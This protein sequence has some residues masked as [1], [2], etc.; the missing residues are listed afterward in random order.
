[1]A[2]IEFSV[3]RSKYKIE[4]PENE[5]A[6]LMRL[7]NKLGERVKK[8]LANFQNIDERTLLIISA[9]TLEDELESKSQSINEILQNNQA[10]N[11]PLE[12]IDDDE[13]YIELAENLENITEYVEKLAKKIEN[14]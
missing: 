3:G 9:L 4:C 11:I 2:I 13:M 10:T 1:M 5:Q 7:A 12:K 6:K 14:Y 8:S